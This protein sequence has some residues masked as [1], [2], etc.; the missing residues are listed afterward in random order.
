[1]MKADPCVKHKLQVLY[2]LGSRI[3]ELITTAQNLS[4]VSEKVA[5]MQ[6]NQA[7]Y[8]LK[9]FHEMVSWSETSSKD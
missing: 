5:R 4:D 6:V 2:L 7:I 1:M 3:Q 9:E 8:D